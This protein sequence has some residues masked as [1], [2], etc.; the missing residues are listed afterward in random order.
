MARVRLRKKLERV[1]REGHPWIWRDAIDGD[2]EPGEVTTVVDR[3]GKVIARGIADAGPIG[4]RVW[5][6]AD[7]QIGPELFARRVGQAAALRDA[8]VP[9]DTDCYRLLH[10]EGDRMPGVVCDVYGAH[11]VVRFDGTGVTAFREPILAALE[12]VLR[13]RGVTA[14]LLRSGRQEQRSVSAVVGDAPRGIV[15][16]REHGMRLPADL[17]TGQKTGMFLDHRESRRRVRELSRGRSVLNLYGYTGGFSV[18]AGLGGA[19]RVTTVDVAPRAIELAREAWAANGL[20]ASAHEGIVADVPAFLAGVERD[21]GKWEL[22]V[23]DPPSF[24]PKE[25]AVPAAIESYTK[26][27]AS[28]V[29]L[30]APGGLLV[31]A[32]CSTHVRGAAFEQ[33]LRD[34]ARAARR[35]LQ[36]LERHGAPADHP[37]LLAFPEGEYLDVIVARVVA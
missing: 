21:G 11:A 29:R 24:A 19:A 34:G 3:R 37:R 17:V 27:H 18:A 1:I 7:E 10:G 13:A 35:V 9:E 22:V 33:T 36:V 2:A 4:V 26:L 32:S 16:V 12:P 20:D 30:L 23:S 31:A 25:S 5:S 15:W 28:C 6:T 8:V 14:L